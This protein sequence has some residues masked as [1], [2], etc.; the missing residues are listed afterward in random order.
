LPLSITNTGNGDLVITSIVINGDPNIVGDYSLSTAT[1]PFRVTPGQK[2]T[3]LVNFAPKA[4]GARPVT[5]TFT[6]NALDNPQSIN[7]TG[8][9]VGP[10]FTGPATQPIEFPRTNVNANSQV[11]VIPIKN[12]GNAS[13]LIS[14][15]QLTGDAAADFIL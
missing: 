3:V 13:M 1:L 6:D 11:V 12:T 7:V 8:N 14:K 4:S 10:V 2:T 15:I 5:L 9:G